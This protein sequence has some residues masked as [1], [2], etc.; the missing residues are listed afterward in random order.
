MPV[1]NST[2]STSPMPTT[3]QLNLNW[4]WSELSGLIAQL[5]NI[6]CSAV[7]STSNTTVP[8][9]F[10]SFNLYAALNLPWGS[11]SQQAISQ[12][13]IAAWGKAEWKMW[14]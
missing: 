1:D 14:I 8:V 10:S 2:N 11:W 4:N 12:L 13:N 9:D 3:P 5:Q 7:N 6:Q